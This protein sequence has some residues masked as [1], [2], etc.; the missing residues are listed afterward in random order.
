M[1]PVPTVLSKLL[2]EPQST[3][4]IQMSRCPLSQPYPFA[5]SNEQIAIKK[6][7]NVPM[8]P[9]PTI[10]SKTCWIGVNPRTEPTHPD[11]HQCPRCS[12]SQRTPTQSASSDKI[13]ITLKNTQMSQCLLSQSQSYSSTLLKR[14]NHPQKIANVPSNQP[15]ILNKRTVQNFIFS[16]VPD[17]PVPTQFNKPP[18]LIHHLHHHQ[19]QKNHKCPK[20]QCPRKPN[21]TLHLLLYIRTISQE[22]MKGWL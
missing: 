5:L 20:S 8:S 10:S 22:P 4:P 11:Q 13:Q 16:N 21:L 15:D 7:T 18:F 17:V 12:L 9:V 3:R 6:H 19:N 2:T 14:V 1:S